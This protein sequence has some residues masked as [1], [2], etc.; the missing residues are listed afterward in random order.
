MYSSPFED[1][2]FKVSDLTVGEVE[3]LLRDNAETIKLLLGVVREWFIPM[4]QN[5]SEEI[6]C[7]G[8]LQDLEVQLPQMVPSVAIAAGLLGE[9]PFW[10]DSVKLED[11]DDD[12]IR[13]KKYD[14]TQIVD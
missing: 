8:W 2:T 14:V 9:I 1:P 11:F 13:W 4:M 5:Y 7:A 3:L 12:P 6:W 10:D